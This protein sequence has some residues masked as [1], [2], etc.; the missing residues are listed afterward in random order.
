MGETLVLSSSHHVRRRRFR[1]R[2]PPPAGVDASRSGR[3]GRQSVQYSTE[4]TRREL[5]KELEEREKAAEE[6]RAARVAAGNSGRATRRRCLRFSRRTPSPVANPSRCSRVPTVTSSAPRPPPDPRPSATRRAPA[7]GKVQRELAMF[8]GAKTWAR[9]STFAAVERERRL[10][11]ADEAG[12]P[13]DESDVD[14]DD[15]VVAGASTL[16][17]TRRLDNAAHRGG[18]DSSGAT[19]R[20]DGDGKDWEHVRARRSWRERTICCPWRRITG[21]ARGD[22]WRG[23]SDARWYPRDPSAPPGENAEGRQA[24]RD[25]YTQDSTAA[26][27][28]RRVSG[29]APG[30]GESALGG[31][32]GDDVLVARVSG[33]PRAVWVWVVLPARVV[34]TP[35]EVTAQ[36]P[37]GMPVPVTGGGDSSRSHWPWLV[38]H[39]RD[40]GWWSRCRRSRVDGTRRARRSRGGRFDP[41]RGVTRSSSSSSP[42]SVG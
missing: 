17:P 18:G 42:S 12:A 19:R 36:V 1:T 33:R 6:A 4:K 39:Q 5:E 35:G 34:E 15:D 11:D 25:A 28:P 2:S 24:P 21:P 22:T 13:N 27:R 40:E 37:A 23:P 38:S 14:V 30:L 8:R 9:R 10:A 32:R 41:S 20:P 3:C 7:S 26:T 16:V 31:R 29:R